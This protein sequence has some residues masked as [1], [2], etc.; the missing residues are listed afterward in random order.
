MEMVAQ[1]I[2]RVLELEEGATRK[3]ETAAARLFHDARERTG[4][5][6]FGNAF[7][8]DPERDR[9]ALGAHDDTT[10]PRLDV[11]HVGPGHV[12]RLLRI[13]AKPE[14]LEGDLELLLRITHDDGSAKEHAARWE[15]EARLWHRLG[16]YRFCD[17]RLHDLCGFGCLRLLFLL[18]L[19]GLLFLRRDRGRRDGL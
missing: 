1:R 13:D 4:E 10:A 3:V 19:G 18:R 17:D 12:D 8:G 14:L 15:D 5:R 6:R 2:G 16:L 11:A 7:D 9:P